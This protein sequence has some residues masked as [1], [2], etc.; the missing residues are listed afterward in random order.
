MH[1]QWAKRD[2]IDRYGERLVSDYGF[3]PA[4][5]GGIREEVKAYVEESAQKA[6]ALPMPEPEEALEGVFAEDWQA[7]GD[8]EAPWSFWSTAAADGN[9]SAPTERRAA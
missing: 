9:G 4:E 7:L 5:V 8:G 2:P 1:E 3:E 6:L